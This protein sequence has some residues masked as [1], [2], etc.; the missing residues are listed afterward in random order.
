MNTLRPSAA[1]SAQVTQAA[2]AAANAVAMDSGDRGSSSTQ[3][4]AASGGGL[5]KA[6]I[7]PPSG[8][9]VDGRRP[10][11]LL[12][13]AESKREEERDVGGCGGGVKADGT[14]GG[15]AA[16]TS[17]SRRR[18]SEES[19]RDLTPEERLKLNRERNR[20]H[21]RRSRE[22]KKAYVEGLKKQVSEL[23]AYRMLVEEAHDLISAHS[24]DV[25]AVFTFASGGFDRLLGMDPTELLG[26]SFLELVDPNDSQEVL[27]SVLATLRRGGIRQ[28]QYRMRP[29]A[30][31]HAAEVET[32]FRLVS[33]RLVAVT[34]VRG[35]SP[36]PCDPLPSA[37]LS[38][39]SA[40][41]SSHVPPPSPLLVQ[42]LPPVSGIRVDGGAGG[43]SLPADFSSDW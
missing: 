9:Q 43:L 6:S 30:G 20:D 17:T 8:V 28:V 32:S 19:L 2:L 37:P 15:G 24:T 13:T 22:R 14:G 11:K 27:R 42:P 25:N 12:R 1:H 26:V 38:I 33:T 36:S 7:R 5:T 35:R 34:R 41:G 23:G 21:S 18:P 16:K 4:E 29:P 40:P 39:P 10:S 31:A 3:E